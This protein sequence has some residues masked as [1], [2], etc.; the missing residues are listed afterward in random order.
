[1]TGLRGLR[2]GL[3]EADLTARLKEALPA[4][5]GRP[6]RP[7]VLTEREKELARAI[8]GRL[9]GQAYLQMHRERGTAPMRSLKVSARAHIHG[10]EGSNGGTPLQASLFLFEQRVREVR[11]REV[12]GGARMHRL[13]TRLRGMDLPAAR[14][15]LAG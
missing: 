7:G 2:P 11:V 8:G 10:L 13:E 1:M 6:L 14:D 4:A 5:L 9:G 3:D 15:L 12:A